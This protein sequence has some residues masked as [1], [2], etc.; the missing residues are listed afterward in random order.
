MK[1]IL[2]WLV[3]ILVTLSAQ[4]QE[5]KP[6]PDMSSAKVPTARD[7]EAIVL[8]KVMVDPN[9][10]LSAT[11]SVVGKLSFSLGVAYSPF[12][13]KGDRVWQ[14]HRVSFAETTSIVWVNAETKAVQVLYPQKKEK[15]EPTSAGDGAKR[16]APEK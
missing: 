16:A 2:M 11:E 15:A 10:G 3:V 7:A 6:L 9:D 4:A 13:K 12:G 8:K 1:S 5:L 14:V